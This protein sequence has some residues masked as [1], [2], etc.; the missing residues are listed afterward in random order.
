MTTAPTSRSCSWA[1]ST[2]RRHKQ[3]LRTFAALVFIQ[4]VLLSS[5][6]STMN[7]QQPA[8][9]GALS[10]RVIAD[11]TSRPVAGAM[12]A[13]GETGR[14]ALSD[15]AGVFSTV[16]IPSGIHIV[17]VRALGFAPFE[18]R[19]RFDWGQRVEYRRCLDRAAADDCRRQGR[20]STSAIVPEGL[21]R[22]STH[23]DGTFSRYH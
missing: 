7:A 13:I 3:G 17:R 2:R 19:I 8:A 11:S 5:S 12:I 6:G 23:G 18:Q 22:S 10:G 20:R 14:S 4:L 15:S 16:G 9:T 1:V 21:R